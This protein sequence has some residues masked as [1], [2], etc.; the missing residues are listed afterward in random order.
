MSRCLCHGRVFLYVLSS[1]SFFFVLCF[2]FSPLFPCFRSVNRFDAVSLT[3]CIQFSREFIAR[4]DC[5]WNIA[6]ICSVYA[7]KNGRYVLKIVQ[8][9]VSIHMPVSLCFCY[10]LIAL[11]KTFRKFWIFHKKSNKRSPSPCYAFFFMFGQ[12][13]AS[14]ISSYDSRSFIIKISNQNRI[15]MDFTFFF[16][17]KL[18]WC[19]LCRNYKEMKRAL[20]FI[21]IF[22]ILINNLEHVRTL[23]FFLALSNEMANKII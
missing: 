17:K 4:M 21:F 20:K 5:I 18:V 12:R 6:T 8:L 22:E 23:P 3:H 1:F 13:T 10:H 15:L 9:N 16:A 14:P 19:S 7:F 11:G 2:F